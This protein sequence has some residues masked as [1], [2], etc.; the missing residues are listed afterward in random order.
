MFSTS[1]VSTPKILQKKV[2]ATCQMCLSDSLTNHLSSPSLFLT[3]MSGQFVN[4]E[5]V[6]SMFSTA[7]FCFRG[8]AV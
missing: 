8:E 7:R 2:V 3:A 1:S 4:S 5:V 6:E